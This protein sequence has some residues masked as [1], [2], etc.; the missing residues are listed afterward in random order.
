MQKPDFP[1]LLKP[2]IHTMTMQELYDLAVVPFNNSRRQLL[3]QQLSNWQSDL[4]NNAGVGARLWIDGSFLTEKP[5]PGD[6]DC[7]AWEP[8][9]KHQNNLI[10]QQSEFARLFDRRHAETVYNLDLYLEYVKDLHREAY[11]SGLMG[12]ARDRRTAKGFAEIVL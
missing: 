6:I 1:A 5:E 3:Y 4:V 9:E 12:F 10:Y 11:W 7:V 8:Y 2:G